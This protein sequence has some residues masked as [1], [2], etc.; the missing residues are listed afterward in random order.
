[1]ETRVGLATTIARAAVLETI[2]AKLGILQF[3]MLQVSTLAAMA[4]IVRIRIPFSLHVFSRAY[5]NPGLFIAH[6]FLLILVVETLSKQSNSL[7]SD[8]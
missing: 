8:P 4:L 6:L 2:C 1:M 7:Y 5:Q 3:N